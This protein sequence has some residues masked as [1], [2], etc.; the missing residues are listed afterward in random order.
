MQSSILIADNDKDNR[1][2]TK[3]R[4]R[5]Q[6]EDCFSDDSCLR[7][8]EQKRNQVRSLERGINEIEA[9]LR[10]YFRT[11]LT[12]TERGLVNTQLNAFRNDLT[13]LD[14]DYKEVL[15]TGSDIQPIRNRIASLYATYT[16]S[17]APYVNPSRMEQFRVA[18]RTIITRRVNI[19]QINENR[20]MLTD[21]DEA[22]IERFIL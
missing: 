4:N 3:K 17:L 13:D 1:G 8:R 11:D 20:R 21:Q 19:R 6:E 7:E 9:T 12:D 2:Q 5:L 18:V 14:D 10:S 15:R 16:D 22:K